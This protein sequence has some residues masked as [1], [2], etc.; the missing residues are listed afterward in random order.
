MDCHYATKLVIVTFIY[1]NYCYH[2]SNQFIAPNLTFTANLVVPEM[3][4]YVIEIVIKQ[5][6]AMDAS[7]CMIQSQTSIVFKLKV[8]LIYLYCLA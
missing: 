3:P 2:A 6:Y 4:D 1:Q 7:D 8:F 5:I